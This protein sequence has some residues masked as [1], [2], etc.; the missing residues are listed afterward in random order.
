MY[1]SNCDLPH[2]TFGL[3]FVDLLGSTEHQ[4]SST[5]NLSSG[6]G[7]VSDHSSCIATKVTGQRPVHCRT[8]KTKDLPCSYRYLPNVF[9]DGSVTR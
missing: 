4:K 9:R 1:L 6:L 3:V 8:S 7:N 2:C 5:L